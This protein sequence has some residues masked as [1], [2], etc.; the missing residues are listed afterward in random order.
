MFKTVSHIIVM[1]LIAVFSAGLSAE[2][3]DIKDPAVAKLVKSMDLDVLTSFSTPAPGVTGYVVKRDSAKPVIIYGLGDFVLSGSLIDG[4]GNDLTRQYAQTQLPG[5][6][7][8]GVAGKLE[9]D[10]HLVTEGAS[11]QPEIYVFAD[12]N[13]VFCHRFWKQTRAWVENG[14][15]QM[16]WVMVGFLKPSSTGYAAAIINA[17]KPAQALEAFESH[18]GDPNGPVQPQDSISA[19]LQAALDQHGQ[20]MSALGFSGTPGLLFKDRNGQWQGIT[21]V[22]DQNQL[23]EA[24]GIEEAE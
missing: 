16:H 15:V 9:D 3:A 7:Y 2:E 5:P 8:K 18:F 23:G 11:W 14:K 6:D 10:P 24:L 4:D 17:D 20:W 12:P 21:G 19:T 1:A 13:C 22:P